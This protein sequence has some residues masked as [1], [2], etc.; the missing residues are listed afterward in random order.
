MHHPHCNWH[1]QHTAC[2]HKEPQQWQDLHLTQPWSSMPACK[3]QCL[4]A[5]DA[6]SKAPPNRHN[7]H[8]RLP[9]AFKNCVNPSGF[10]KQYSGFALRTLWNVRTCAGF[11]FP[12]DF[13][14]FFISKTCF[15][16]FFCRLHF[17]NLRF[18]C[19]FC[20]KAAFRSG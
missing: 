9:W 8:Q 20:F 17:I 11:T 10:Y 14:Y 15:Q 3:S 6:E 16:C 5:C 18:I 1:G 12:R 4:A 13:H 7:H 19:L 2:Q